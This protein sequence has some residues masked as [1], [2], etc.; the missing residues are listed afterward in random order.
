MRLRSV[1]KKVISVILGLPILLLG[2]ILIPLPGPGLLLTFIGLFIL[3]LAFESTKPWEQKLRTHF[4]VM[5][6]EA[7]RKYKSGQNLNNL[8]SICRSPLFDN[9]I[10][11]NG[12]EGSRLGQSPKI[13]G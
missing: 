1:I 2:I 4:K 11:K 10:E 5:F 13:D 9:P 7:R 3:S 6:D 8:C 12:H